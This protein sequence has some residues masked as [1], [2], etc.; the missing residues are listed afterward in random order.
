MFQQEVYGYNKEEVDNYIQTMKSGYESKLMVE[1]LKVLEAERKLLE[2]KNERHE[3]E[4]KEK[5][6]INALNV[7]E[8]QK[9]AQEEG[10]KRINALVISKLELLI[11]ELE[12]KFPQFKRDKKYADILEEFSDIVASFKKETGTP[13]VV[14]QV[15]SE[16]DS[17]RALLN[18]M[19]E[20]RKINSAPKDVHIE[21]KKKP[22]VYVPPQAIP[23]GESGFSFEEALNPT[24]DLEEIMKA[25]DFYNDDNKK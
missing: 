16:N 12:L 9:K 25:F 21:R 3:I 24:E 22:D 23:D 15:N 5:S 17:M 18:K 4:S 1:K 20:Y 2:N 19:Q 6:I 7:I 11:N 10:S 8:K 14:K 13:N